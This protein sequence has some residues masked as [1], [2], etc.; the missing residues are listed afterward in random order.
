MKTIE[1]ERLLLE[2]LD[3]DR[4][5]EF[6]ALTADAQSMRYWR[7]LGTFSRQQ[8]EERSG[9]ALART[10]ERGFGRR[11]IVLKDTGAGIGFTETSSGEGYE[12][13]APDDVELGSDATPSAWG[14][15]YATEA[16][17]AA[18]TRPSSASG[19]KPSSRCTT[20]KPGVRADHGEARHGHERDLVDHTGGRTA[21]IGLTRERWE[22]LRVSGATILHPTASVSPKLVRVGG[23]FAPNVSTMP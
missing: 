1:T 9:R 19:C 10:R 16:G 13:V 4:L 8:A 11:W 12:E 22:H 20:T 18:R 7:P 2:P 15:G 21:C 3:E 5:E 14:N 23:D 17:Q 6:V